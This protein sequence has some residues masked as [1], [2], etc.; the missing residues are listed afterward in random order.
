MARKTR[1]SED[2]SQKENS[3]SGVAIKVKPEKM[4]KGA[5]VK[6]EKT[7]G[8]SKGKEKASQ[9]HESDGDEAGAANGRLDRE[10]EDDLFE[11][12]DGDDQGDEEEEED[13]NGPARG[14]KRLRVD[15]DGESRSVSPEE[16]DVKPRTRIIT[17]PRGDDG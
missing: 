7:T 15:E 17:L 13:G 6:Q 4:S 3:Q 2:D 14:R 10:E 8:S 11:G 9:Q 16:K 5:K 1:A 12:V